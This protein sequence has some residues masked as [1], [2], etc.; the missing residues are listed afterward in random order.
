[1]TFKKFRNFEWSKEY[2]YFSTACSAL[3]RLLFEH[4]QTT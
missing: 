1:M 3:T 4:T 2:F